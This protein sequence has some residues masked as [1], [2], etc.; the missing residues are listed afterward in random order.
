MVLLTKMD[1]LQLS[2]SLICSGA[3]KQPVSAFK[4]L[5]RNVI[6][7]LFSCRSRNLVTNLL[8]KFSTSVVYLAVC[9]FRAVLV[10]YPLAFGRVGTCTE[11]FPSEY[12]SGTASVRPSDTACRP[13]R[14]DPQ[15]T[16]GPTARDSSC[17]SLPWTV[18][19]HPKAQRSEKVPRLLTATSQCSAATGHLEALWSSSAIRFLNCLWFCAGCSWRFPPQ[20]S[21]RCLNSVI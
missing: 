17:P 19:W 2:L 20:A 7:G 16:W 8:C 21:W 3:F 15:S 14:P 9:L 4:G 1:H 10:I 18:S 5:T 11:F 12:A 6:C 13:K